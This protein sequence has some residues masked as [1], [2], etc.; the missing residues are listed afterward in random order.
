MKKLL[1][2]LLLVLPFCITTSIYSVDKSYFLSP[3][4]YKTDI[5]IRS[6]SRGDGQFASR[7]NG[8]RLHRGIDFSAETGTSVL[9]VRSGKVIAAASNRVMGNY[10]I[11]RH[12]Q[13][14]ITIYGHLDQIYVTKGDY[15]KQGHRIGAVGRTGNAIY[16][17]IQPHLHF[18]VRK[19]GVSENPMDYL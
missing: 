2:I 19:D 15:I 9:A 11:L 5:I 18:E 10:I 12:S 3:I 4:Q 16:N 7:R 6:D 17:G 14:I 13:N 1:F 8:G